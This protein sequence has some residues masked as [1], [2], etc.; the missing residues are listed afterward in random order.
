LK[1]ESAA[2]LYE[3]IRIPKLRHLTDRGGRLAYDEFP[4]FLA[5]HAGTL[6]TITLEGPLMTIY[7][8]GPNAFMYNTGIRPSWFDV[9]GIML[10]MPHLSHLHLSG[11]MEDSAR[12]FYAPYFKC[13]PQRIP[14]S[15]S[16]TVSDGEIATQLNHAIAAGFVKPSEDGQGRVMVWFRAD[17]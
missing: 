2:F 17:N 3:N 1:D 4:R 13:R 9:F 8:K 16:V 10:K 11:L 12:S 6:E 5:D 15:T 7:A 14:G